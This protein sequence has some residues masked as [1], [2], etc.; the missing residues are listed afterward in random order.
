MNGKGRSIL[1]Y[2]GSI[3]LILAMVMPLATV[4]QAQQRGDEAGVKLHQRLDEAG[5]KLHQRLDEAGAKLYHS[6]PV[7]KVPELSTSALLI[8]GIGLTGLA[9]YCLRRRKRG[10]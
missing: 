4:S 6:K 7:K 5:A 9:G 2:C 10:A 8:L 3:M 1:L